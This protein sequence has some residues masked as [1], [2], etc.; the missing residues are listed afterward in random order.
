MDNN[1][2]RERVIYGLTV[3]LP[4][5]PD[6]SQFANY[7]LPQRDQKWRPKAVPKD[8]DQW[9]HENQI[10]FIRKEVKIRE[11]GYWFLNNGNL[12]YIT[13]IHYFYLTYWHLPEGLPKFTDADRDFFYFWDEC[14]RDNQCFGM[15]DVE[16]RRGGKTA[17]STCILYE[18]ASKMNNVNCGIQSKTNGDAKGVFS[19]LKNSWK[20]L[21][22]IWKPTDTGD[23]NPASALRFEE[24]GVRT[25]KG[26]KKSYK[27]VLNSV[28]DFKPSVEEAYDGEKLERLF[29][30]EWGKTI[31]VNVATRWSIQKF[32][33]ISSFSDTDTDIIGKAIF[34]TTIEELE[35]KGGKNAKILW[36]GSDTNNRGSDGRTRSGLYR[37]F[38]PAYYGNAKYMDEYGYS[39]IEGAKKYLLKQREGLT[40]V[41]LFDLIRKQPFSAE[42][43]FVVSDKSEVFPAFK[44]YEQKNYNDSIFEP[45]Y[46]TGNFEWADGKV[47][48]FNNPNGKWK[49]AC[50][51]SDEM[52][53]K[54][55]MRR[56]GIAPGNINFGLLGV[57]PY[58]HKTTVDNK[59]SDAAMHLFRTYDPMEPIRSGC[60]IVE[61]INRPPVPEIFFDDALKT[62]V[63]YGIEVLPE[64]QK[65]GLI[66]YFRQK[67]YINY[68]KETNTSDTTKG[69]L[70]KKIEGISTSG[71]YTREAMMNEMVTYIY[72]NIGK[73]DKAA[74][75]KRGITGDHYGFCP[76]EELMDQW[77]DFDVNKWTDYDAVVS[78]ML[79][80]LGVRG[81]K[82]VK[83]K[84]NK[85]FN[86]DDFFPTFSI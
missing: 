24:P 86:P 85:G 20:R 15:L 18:Y 42:E 30:D 54:T 63:Y 32:C 47:I 6:I 16:N 66:N 21:H 31:E 40:G 53:N 11:E 62:A 79:A 13:G 69:G 33:L 9:P 27:T 25:T 71:D 7:D 59:R 57:D 50:Q 68:I 56:N 35:R 22:S 65:P 78:S 72:E 41:A 5:P 39:D 82:N 49:V 55:E 12:E 46:Q 36:E 38:K 61:Y 52:S 4:E 26:V 14:V 34:T 67:G 3:H 1:F 74:L 70:S 64:N 75:D 45:L 83:K 51:L 10:A 77:L 23:T 28:I 58:D 81:L 76:F 2:L 37:Y 80:V 8:F 43:A 19:K 84:K 17:K 44:I 60:F 29:V 48:F 73:L